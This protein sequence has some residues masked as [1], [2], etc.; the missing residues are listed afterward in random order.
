MNLRNRVQLIGNLGNE[1]M[2]RQFESG[3]KIARFSLATNDVY[4][5]DDKFVKNVQW[6]TIVCWDKVAEIA[7]KCLVTG[8]EV[9]IDG[10]IMQRSYEDKE[11]K[12]QYITEIVANS[13]LCR[14]NK[15]NL[16]SVE[17]RA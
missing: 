2:V 15:V 12:K 6:H 14:A 4:K 3:R 17:Y 11:G 5:E 7:E 13:L 9:V 10:S 16:G 8:S 1:P